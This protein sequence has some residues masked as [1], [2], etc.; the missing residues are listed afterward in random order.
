MMTAARKRNTNL[1]LSIFPSFLSN[2]NPFETRTRMI[3]KMKHPC[4]MFE[5]QAQRKTLSSINKFSNNLEYKVREIE[6]SLLFLISSGS[7][8]WLRMETI[9]LGDRKADRC[10]IFL[11]RWM[12]SWVLI[13]FCESIIIWFVSYIID[14]I[15]RPI[16][17]HSNFVMGKFG[18]RLDGN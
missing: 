15:S 4:I 10:S 16:Y 12:T 6:A 1:F 18:A 17:K 11:W 3:R 5:K 2:R 13:G 8:N 7:A 9:V 14:R